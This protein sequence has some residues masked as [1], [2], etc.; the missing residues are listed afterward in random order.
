MAEAIA[1]RL[2]PDGV[3]VFSA[4]VLPRPVHPLVAP[5]MAR[6]GVDAHRLLSKSLEEFVGDHFDQ[7]ILINSPYSQAPSNVPASTSSLTWRM[8]DPSAAVGTDRERRKS[9]LWTARELQHRVESLLLAAPGKIR[10]VRLRTRVES[11]KAVLVPPP[12]FSHA[13]PWPTAVA[14]HP[15]PSTARSVHLGLEV[16]GFRVRSFHSIDTCLEALP[17]IEPSLLFV[18]LHGSRPRVFDLLRA[19]QRD[20]TDWMGA[21]AWSDPTDE[22]ER[23]TA[24]T[25]GISLWIPRAA[26]QEEVFRILS[27][28]VSAPGRETAPGVAWCPR[29]W[30]RFLMGPIRVDVVARVAEAKGGRRRITAMQARLLVY[31]AEHATAGR[32]EDAMLREVW[33][34]EPPARKSNRVHAA[35]HNLRELFR[36]EG[37]IVGWVPGSGYR[38]S[39]PFSRI[40]LNP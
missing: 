35:I 18:D 20:K 21:V 4:G 38:L 32:P 13:L 8:N 11:A 10:P 23:R 34:I 16:A 39:D 9:F 27:S 40:V 25:L 1:R 33:G 29:L 3:E 36:S 6:F 31:L 5:T 37:D 28:F 2:S 15:D 14:Y 12:F 19:V 7:L 17:S 22:Q 24:A 26:P 30:G